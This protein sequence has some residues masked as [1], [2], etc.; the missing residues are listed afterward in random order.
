[1]EPSI[2]DQ[3]IVGVS[4]FWQQEVVD[5]YRLWHLH[6]DGIEVTQSIQHYRADAHLTDPA[7]RGMDNSVQLVAY[8]AAW[9]RVYVRSG[10]LS[11]VP[12]VTATL[13]VARRNFLHGFDVV[14]TLT[15]Q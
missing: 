15:P 14:R 2:L 6:V 9:V 7:D 12:N 13:E 1:M 4:R 8:K 11:S 5:R 10:M 3:I